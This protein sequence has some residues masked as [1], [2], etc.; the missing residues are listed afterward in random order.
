MSSSD[1]PMPNASVRGPGWLPY[2]LLFLVAFGVR[3]V[4]LHQLAATPFADER[5][6]IEDTIYYDQRAREIGT[7]N[8]S[9]VRGCRD[10]SPSGRRW[11][12]GGG[13]RGREGVREESSWE[14]SHAELC[15]K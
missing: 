3:A 14:R 15:G 11:G 5:A 12:G 7:T 6:L 10:S 9:R 4:F 1:D 8:A 13:S 2:A